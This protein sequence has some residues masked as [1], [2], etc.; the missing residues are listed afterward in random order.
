VAVRMMAHVEGLIAKGSKVKVVTPDFISPD[1]KKAGKLE[2]PALQSIPG[3]VDHVTLCTA[4]TPVY[5]KNMCMELCFENLF[6]FV[7]LI[8]DFQP[9]VVHATQEASIQLIALACIYCDV[10]LVVSVHT[11]VSQIAA[12]DDGFSS[13]GGIIGRVHARIAVACTHLGYRNW[14]RA[15]A[16]FF[17][18]SQQSLVIL[19]NAGVGDSQ[20]RTTIWGPVVDRKV[21]RIDQPEDQ[22]KRTREDLTFGIPGAFLMVYVGRV[23]AE[24]DVQF[25]VD[26]LGRAPENVVLALVGSGSAAEELSKLHGKHNRLHC[27]GKFIGRPEVALALRAA[28]ACVSASTMET[29]GFTAMEALSCGTPCLMVRAQGFAMHLTHGV[30]ARLW[31]PLD[32][33]SFDAELKTLMETKRENQWSRESLRASMES[34]SVSACTDRAVEVYR[35]AGPV[36]HRCLKVL[37]AFFWFFSN[38]IVKVIVG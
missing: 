8:R 5:R 37:Q 15:G 36:N 21:F 2:K 26:A 7:Q 9:D 19:K 16:V 24:K 10:P 11:D 6:T 22:V 13:L 35:S 3:V 12:R 31:T 27:T 1:A 32:S 29:V 34:A 18:V 23:T 30:N 25:L 17:P 14:A 4:L 38:L 20:V 28:D 33:A